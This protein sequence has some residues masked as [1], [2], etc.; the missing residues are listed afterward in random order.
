MKV[1][2]TYLKETEEINLARAFCKWQGF[3]V[4]EQVGPKFSIEFPVM[5]GFG[6]KGTRDEIEVT[7]GFVN[8]VHLLTHYGLL[9]C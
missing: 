8:F 6:I 9:R 1:K 7:S 4:E 3:T 2:I 5:P